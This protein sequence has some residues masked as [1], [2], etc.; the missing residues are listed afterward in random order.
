MTPPLARYRIRGNDPLFPEVEELGILS[1]D[2][3]CRLSAEVTRAP[4][5]HVLLTAVTLL[6]GQDCLWRPPTAA[7]MQA[8]NSPGTVLLPVERGSSQ[9]LPVLEATLQRQYGLTVERL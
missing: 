9:F 1:V 4:A 2:G 6:N 5:A 7:E 8:H 3:D